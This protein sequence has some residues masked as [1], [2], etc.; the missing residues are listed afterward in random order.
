M[1]H[2]FDCLLYGICTVQYNQSIH[3]LCCLFSCICCHTTTNIVKT[4][5]EY[6]KNSKPQKKQSSED[7]ND[8]SKV[9]VLNEYKYFTEVSLIIHPMQRRKL[10]LSPEQCSDFYTEHH[11]KLTFPKLTAYMSSGPIIALTLARDNAIAHWKYII[12]PL[13]A[14]DS[15][16]EWFVPFETVFVVVVFCIYL[17]LK[18]KRRLIVKQTS[19]CHYPAESM[20]VT[21]K[22]L[23]PIKTPITSLLSALR[24]QTTVFQ[25]I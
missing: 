8:Q 25:N 24:N 19:N 4:L 10:Q 11:G 12:G 3:Y 16:P 2:V 1:I 20:L 22:V 7:E 15:H 5:N 17:G 23:H 18:C 6:N 9:V 13:K 14:T 21:R